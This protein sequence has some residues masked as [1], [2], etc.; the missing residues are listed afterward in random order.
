MKH[1]WIEAEAAWKFQARLVESQQEAEDGRIYT[2][3]VGCH[4]K[5]LHLRQEIIPDLL[6]ARVLGTGP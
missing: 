2:S 4:E 6:A 5:I 1:V 3:S